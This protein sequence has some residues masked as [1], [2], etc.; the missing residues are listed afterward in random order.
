MVIVGNGG[1]DEFFAN[2]TLGLLAFFDNEDWWAF[3]PTGLWCVGV[4][5]RDFRVIRSASAAPATCSVLISH[6]VQLL[7]RLADMDAKIAETAPFESR[8]RRCD[9]LACTISFRIRLAEHCG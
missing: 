1:G 3:L 7:K 8:N 5:G 2:A 6:Q 9:R 4:A